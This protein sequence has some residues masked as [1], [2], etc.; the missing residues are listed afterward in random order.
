MQGSLGMS[1]KL[2]NSRIVA[3]L[4][5][6]LRPPHSTVVKLLSRPLSSMDPVRGTCNGR[7]WR[8]SSPP[9]SWLSGESHSPLTTLH[10]PSTTIHRHAWPSSLGGRLPAS[11]YMKAA[12]ALGKEEDSPGTCSRERSLSRLR[13][14]TRDHRAALAGTGE[15]GS[16]E[17]GRGAPGTTDSANTEKAGQ[18]RRAWATLPRPAGGSVVMTSFP[19]CR[20]KRKY[21]GGAGGGGSDS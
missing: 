3:Q 14:F 2:L 1:L 4:N 7:A 15:S 16:A 12:E 18:Q 5:L 11:S 19:Q 20:I 9:H 17:A 8:K 13:T 6:Q 10:T 21:K